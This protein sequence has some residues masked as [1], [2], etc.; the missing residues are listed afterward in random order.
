MSIIS[1]E[2]AIRIGIESIRQRNDI[3]PKTKEQAIRLLGNLERA[4]WYKNWTRESVVL[5]LKGFK[6]RTGKAPTV[7]N[8]KE[9]GMPKSATIQSVFGMSP[10]LVLKRLFPENRT[11]NKADSMSSNLFGFESED[12]WLNCFAEQFNKHKK[13]GMSSKTYNRLR[14]TDTP[15]WSTIA[16]HC[17]ISGWIELVK[18]S[19][20]EYVKKPKETV[21]SI[22]VAGATSPLIE[23]LDALNK[24]RERLNKE[25]FDLINQRNTYKK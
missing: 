9:H 2:N 22:Y 19:G 20:V 13:E 24:E 10:S 11:L 16:N 4:D 1:T 21:H 23:K 25:Y 3:P 15:A 5:A 12:D 18:K 17:N 6:E 7:T 14:D 8:L